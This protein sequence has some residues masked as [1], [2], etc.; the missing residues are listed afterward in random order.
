[1]QLLLLC[2]SFKRLWEHWASVPSAHF[3]LGCM[4]S[5]CAGLPRVAASLQSCSGVNSTITAPEQLPVKDRL[6]LRKN[7]RVSWDVCICSSSAR[8]LHR[9]ES[10]LIRSQII[11][12]GWHLPYHPPNDFFGEVTQ[13]QGQEQ[14]SWWGWYGMLTPQMARMCLT[15]ALSVKAVTWSRIQVSK[16]AVFCNRSYNILLGASSNDL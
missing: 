4:R 8:A 12:P 11:L 15:Q 13:V 16:A 14:V 10:S 3:L 2:C 7:D 6:W 9:S 5:V 1:M